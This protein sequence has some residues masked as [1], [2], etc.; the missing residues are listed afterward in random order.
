[1]KMLLDKTT[2]I[3]TF[4]YLHPDCVRL[5]M[6]VASMDSS[7][8]FFDAPESSFDALGFIVIPLTL[9][10]SLTAIYKAVFYVVCKTRADG[11]FI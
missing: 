1:M 2:Y 11:R 3:E 9:S 8:L 7:P 4:L 6:H 5:W 10:S